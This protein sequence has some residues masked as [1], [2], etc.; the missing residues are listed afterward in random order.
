[1]PQFRDIRRR[2]AA[3]DWSL[4]ATLSGPAD[5]PHPI[6]DAGGRVLRELPP[7]PELLLTLFS[8]DEAAAL[9][10]CGDLWDRLCHQGQTAPADLPAYDFLLAGA[11]RLADPLKVELLDI[12]YQ[13]AAGVAGGGSAAPWKDALRERFRAH[14]P[15]YE[16]LAAGGNEDVAAYARLILE[17]L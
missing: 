16:A 9:A 10:A 7:V 5:A 8:G 2:I 3:T 4:Y 15:R 13:I 17:Q 11:E 1:M 14:R 12:L 6:R